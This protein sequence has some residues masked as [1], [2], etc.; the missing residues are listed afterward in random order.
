MWTKVSS[1]EDMSPHAGLCIEKRE[2]QGPSSS[3]FYALAPPLANI[4]VRVSYRC[5]LVGAS[6]PLRALL[7]T[8]PAG[9]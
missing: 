4:R 8:S 5:C 9:S 2:A 3:S 7:L 6:V 1:H